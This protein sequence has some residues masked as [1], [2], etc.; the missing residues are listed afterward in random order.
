MGSGTTGIAA[1]ILGR[2]FIGIEYDEEK[3]E[4]AETR[5]AK[6]DLNNNKIASLTLDSV[7]FHNNIKKENN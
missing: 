1:L 3:F 5:L 4:I 6:Q 7:H 2:K